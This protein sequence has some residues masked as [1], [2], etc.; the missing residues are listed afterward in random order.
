M[1]ILGAGES[2]VGAAILAQQQGY[3]VF[4]SDAGVIAEKYKAE[5]DGMST[6]QIEM[7]KQLIAEAVDGT[8]HDLLYL[9]ED[10]DWIKL[11]LESD[12]TLIEDVRRVAGADIQAY[13]FIWAERYSKERRTY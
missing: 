7:T 10:A 13:I 1:V 12:G 9:L 2:G 3:D 5:L 8:L 6:A 4:V 11:R